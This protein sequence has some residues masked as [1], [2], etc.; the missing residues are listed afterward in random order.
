MTGYTSAN[1]RVG[2]I[3]RLITYRVGRGG[4]GTIDT[5]QGGSDLRISGCIQGGEGY[6]HKMEWPDNHI[7]TSDDLNRDSEHWD[8]LFILFAQDGPL[9]SLRCYLGIKSIQITPKIPRSRLELRR[10][11]THTAYI[12]GY[13]DE[14]MMWDEQGGHNVAIIQILPRPPNT[15]LLREHLFISE[16]PQNGIG[17]HGDGSMISKPWYRQCN[18]GIWGKD[19]LQREV[20]NKRSISNS[21]L[22]GKAKYPVRTTSDRRERKGWRKKRRRR[23]RGEREGGTMGGG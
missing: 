18:A 5:K 15:T 6:R 9:Y 12:K 19:A 11:K 17:L 2:R 8:G 21:F 14:G 1:V 20:Y 7:T 16:S 22:A 4:G 13:Y 10:R 3:P 23:R